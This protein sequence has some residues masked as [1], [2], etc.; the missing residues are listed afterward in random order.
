M[1]NFEIRREVVAYVRKGYSVAATART[2]GI[3]EPAVRKFYRLYEQYGLEGLNYNFRVEVEVQKK[4][5]LDR[6]ELLFFVKDNPNLRT[7]DYAKH[8]GCSDNYIR[9]ILCMYGLSKEKRQNIT[10]DFI[11][12]VVLDDTI[13]NA[14]VLERELQ[15]AKRRVAALE[16]L[17]LKQ[18]KGN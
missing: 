4:Q 16:E 8:F 5:V 9:Q 7:R 18:K 3:S 14:H 1:I 11:D 17:L 10:D 12:E 15:K 2:F 13:R 6:R